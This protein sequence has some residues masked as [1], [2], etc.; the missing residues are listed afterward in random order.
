MSIPSARN[1]T[2]REFLGQASCAGVGTAALMS[3]LLTLRL[4]NSLSAQTAGP[5]GDY[6]ALVCLF[7]AGGN[8]SFN[9]LVPTTTGE[10]AA[11][12]KVRGNLAI[13][14]ETLLSV[15][16][17]NLGGRTLGIHPSM[18]E[19]RDLFGTGRLAFVANVGSLIR[20]TTLA[21]VKARRHLP[22]S[23]YSHSD[24]I[25]Q[26]QTCIP[27]QRTAIGWGGRAADIIRSLNA[28]G[29]VS[30]NIS[31]SGQSVFLTGEQAFTYAVGASGATAL[32][33]YSPTAVNNLMATRAKG[34][35]NLVDQTYRNLLEQTYAESTRDAID[36]FY[37][38][39]GAIGTSTL[40]TTVPTGNALA[41]NLA[42]IARIISA[43]GRFG[44]RR[45]IFFVQLGG[46]DHHDEVIENQLTMLRTVSQAIGFFNTALNEIG[47][48]DRVSLFTASDFGRT[49][50]SN[51]NGSDH[52]WGGNHLVMGGAVRGGKVYGD[53]ASG[54]YPDLQNLAAIDTGQGRLIPGVAVD[55]YARDLLSWFGV[56]AG[57][58]DYVLPGFSGRFGGRPELGLFSGSATTSSTPSST[59][60]PA[61]AVPAP[62]PT[63][64]AGGS[65][66]GGAVSPL[67]LGG[68]GALALLRLRQR[69]KERLAA[70]R[71]KP[72]VSPQEKGHAGTA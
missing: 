50:T 71:A 30:M 69:R 64:P 61:P 38:F 57:D 4:A 3:T 8:D 51:G 15:T 72:S 21:D 42:M 27:D 22:L 31:L 17:T 19:V 23:L 11:Y 5:S 6:R 43:N 26:W 35:E 49:L 29:L 37:E 56:G 9:M 68:L 55:E 2:R 62:A 40:S 48:S 14:R 1:L 10:Y 12:A 59:T 36:S 53:A 70:E 54:Y 25:K 52:A 41:N 18:S 58:M 39:S 46:W 47:Y 45:Q 63:P 16:P 7:L 65:A 20:P 44:A 24:Q 34:V 32:T 66:G 33:G 13:A 67:F 60:T 28:P